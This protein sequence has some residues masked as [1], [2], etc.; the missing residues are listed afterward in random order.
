MQTYMFATPGSLHVEAPVFGGG[1]T[2]LAATNDPTPTVPCVGGAHA[3]YTADTSPRSPT[4]P[5]AGRR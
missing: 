1:V 3:D 5:R 2:I 4:C